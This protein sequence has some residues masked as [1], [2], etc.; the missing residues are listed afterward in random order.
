MA[1]SRAMT[2]SSLY[3]SAARTAEAIA[4]MRTDTAATLYESA[5]Y[6]AIRPMP[7]IAS[8]AHA[9]SEAIADRPFRPCAV[10]VARKRPTSAAEFRAAGPAPVPALPMR[11]KMRSYRRC[12]ARDRSSDDEAREANDRFRRPLRKRGWIE[13]ITVTSA[14]RNPPARHPALVTGIAQGQRPLARQ[15]SCHEQAAY[16]LPRHR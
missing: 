16:M 7:V 13:A 3:L 2:G 4:R 6:R 11:S 8:E 10:D 9:A 5:D 15:I 12:R 1:T 14:H